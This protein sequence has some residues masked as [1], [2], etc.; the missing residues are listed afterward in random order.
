VALVSW[1]ASRSR[2]EEALLYTRR[3]NEGKTERER[4]RE[5]ERAWGGGAAESYA[6]GRREAARTGQ[7][8]RRSVFA[9]QPLCPFQFRST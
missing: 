1:A 4:E 3:D 6:T 9:F 7:D 5:R 8:S 2:G